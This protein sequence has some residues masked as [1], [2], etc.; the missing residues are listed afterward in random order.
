M[1]RKFATQY[2]EFLK[3]NLKTRRKRGPLKI[4]C[5]QCGPLCFTGSPPLD[6]TNAELCFAQ[7]NFVRMRIILLYNYYITKQL[8]FRRGFKYAI[9]KHEQT[10][11]Y[12]L[13]TFVFAF[14]FVRTFL[15]FSS[16]KNDEYERKKMRKFLFMRRA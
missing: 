11:A 7:A 13:G 6:Y 2:C 16:K 5:N 10:M 8:F 14:V 12:Q 1:F 9:G 4:L 3:Q 15:R